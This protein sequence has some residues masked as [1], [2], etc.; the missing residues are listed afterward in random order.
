M[1]TDL[2]LESTYN[3]NLGAPTGIINPNDDVFILLK[4]I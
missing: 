4:S 3:E 2:N 1:I